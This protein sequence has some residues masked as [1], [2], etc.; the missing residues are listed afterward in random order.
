M[1][2]LN[3]SGECMLTRHDY[4]SRVNGMFGLAWVDAMAHLLSQADCQPST[5]QMLV[6]T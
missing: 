4:H 6:R 5:N 1:H 2:V 3:P